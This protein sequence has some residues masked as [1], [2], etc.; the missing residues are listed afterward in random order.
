MIKL[1]FS[2]SFAFCNSVSLDVIN[3]NGTEDEWESIYKIDTWN[4]GVHE[5]TLY[6]TDA[7]IDVSNYTFGE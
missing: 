4:I 2:L 3:Y 7:T 5:C 6:C 1:P